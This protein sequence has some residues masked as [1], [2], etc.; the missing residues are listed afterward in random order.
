MFLQNIN[1]QLPSQESNEHAS[2]ATEHN[3]NQ[4]HPSQEP[5][6]DGSLATEHSTRS[7][8]SF[9]EF[10]PAIAGSIDPTTNQPTPPAEQGPSRGQ[11]RHR[12]G[13][14][15]TAQ[16]ARQQLVSAAQM[17]AQAELANSRS[18]TRAIDLLAEVVSVLR[19][20]EA[21]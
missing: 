21:R 2:L 7:L 5:N 1:Q 4:Q 9:T 15:L 19:R 10:T 3:I 11:R 16:A 20:I 14:R 8:P 12:Q 13:P 6:E 18:I 17:R